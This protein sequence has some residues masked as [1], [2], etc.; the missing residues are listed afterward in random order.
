MVRG[1]AALWVIGGLSFAGL[2]HAA[3]PGVDIDTAATIYQ[4]AQ[5]REQVRASLGTMPAQVRQMF[6]KDA[7]AKLSPSSSRPSR[8]P[9][10]AAFA[11]MCSRRR[12]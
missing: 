12:L 5:V 2:I 1:S 3:G 4:A 8:P 10:S 6:E 11:S 7:S 9:L